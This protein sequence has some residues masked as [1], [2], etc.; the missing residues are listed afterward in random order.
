VRHHLCV[1][2]SPAAPPPPGA[3]GG[4]GSDHPGVSRLLLVEDDDADAFLVSELLDLGEP[5]LDVTRATNLAEALK[6]LTV[7]PAPDVV[8]LDLG[9]PDAEGLAIVPQIVSAAPGSAVLVLTGLS[10]EGRGTAAV[11]AGA[12][13]YLVKGQVDEWSLSRAVRYAAGRKRVEETTRR[14]VEWDLEKKHN[15]RLERGLLPTPLLGRETW[16]VRTG[17]RPGQDRSLLGGDFFDAVQQADRRLHVVVGDVAGHGPDE[18]ALGVLVRAAWRTLVLAGTTPVDV[19]PMLT[20]LLVSE[21][22]SEEVF[23]TAVYLVLEPD[24][25]SAE[26][27]NAGHPAPASVPAAPVARFSVAAGPPLGV[28]DGFSWPPQ[29]LDT[30]GAFPLLVYTD[31]LVE[32]LAR[33]GSAARPGERLGERLGEAGLLE[34]LRAEREAGRDGLIDRLI[35]RA[36]QAHGQALPDDV[37]VLLIEPLDQPQD[38]RADHRLDLRLDQ[39][40]LR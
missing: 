21:R 35:R 24:G 26:V 8:M 39:G 9:L 31:G 15:S 22:L 25:A 13:D 7:G 19:L 6:H 37:A 30:T 40:S 28:L 4:V 3:S 33:P 10:D 38:Q 32:G 5:G 2:A 14:M 17:Y 27:F 1:S 36:E 12:Q 18:A 29:R 16:S 23:A 20:R 34:F 11:A